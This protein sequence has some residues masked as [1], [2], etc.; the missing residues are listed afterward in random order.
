MPVDCV[1]NAI[2]QSRSTVAAAGRLLLSFWIALALLAALSPR[3]LARAD[4]PDAWDITGVTAGSTVRLHAA[5]SVRSAVVKQLPHDSQG[6]E[7]LGCKPARPSAGARAADARWCK[8]RFQ[9]VQGWI[10][11]RYLA[12]G[13]RATREVTAAK[14]AV[15]AWL[16]DC[17][18]AECA[19]EQ[20]AGTGATLTKLRIETRPANNA[21]FVIT[22][23]GI[24]ETGVLSIAMDGEMISAGPVG[25]LRAG[26]GQ[27]LV[28]PPDDVTL[29]LLRKMA[30][31]KTMAL[32][33][34]GD[35]KAAE[36]NLGRFTQALQL[37]RR[38]AEGGRR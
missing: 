33:V 20:S 5:P 36:F 10:S 22:R 31:R 3:V 4:G 14:T 23:A 9:G 1:D 18:S 28:L 21:R 34:T 2:G 8:V 17:S 6:L 38:M 26:D 15:G 35:E 19:V 7:N 30:A 29:G 24:P 16:I 12:E 11:G 32:A 27:V 37:A 13:Q 25:P